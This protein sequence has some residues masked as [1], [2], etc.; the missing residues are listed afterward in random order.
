MTD[1]PRKG[2]KMRIVKVETLEDLLIV[3][4]QREPGETM[5]LE[6][7]GE[8]LA[9]AGQPVADPSLPEEEKPIEYLEAFGGEI[10][11]YADLVS[12]DIS[13]ILRPQFDGTYVLDLRDIHDERIITGRKKNGALAQIK[14][15]RCLSKHGWPD[16]RYYMLKRDDEENIVPERGDNSRDIYISTDPE[17]WTSARIG[18]AQKPAISAAAV[19]GAWLLA[20]PQYGSTPDMKV[21]IEVAN[22]IKAE[23]GKLTQPF[24][25][26]G[27]SD[28]YYLEAGKA[29]YDGLTFYVTGDNPLHPIV[30]TRFG[31]GHNPSG[32]QFGGNGA[33]LPGNI[34]FIGVDVGMR[35]ARGMENVLVSDCN[36][37]PY[38]GSDV[39]SMGAGFTMYRMTGLD[40]QREFP[41]KIGGDAVDT[42][43]DENANR[44]SGAYW[45]KVLGSLVEAC[46]YDHN[47]WG[48]GYSPLRLWNNGKHPQPPSVFS[49]NIY[50]QKFNAD[51]T[52]KDIL[53]MRSASVAGQ[54]RIGGWQM[55]CTSLDN[56]IAFQNAGVH[57][58][59][60]EPDKKTENG[61]FPFNLR[62]AAHIGN[63]RPYGHQQGGKITGFDWQGARS[64]D[65]DCVVLHAA[66]PDDPADIASKPKHGKAATWGRG[67]KYS[68]LVVI[69]WDGD[70]NLDGLN[71]AVAMQITV[72]RWIGKELGKDRGSIQE[73]ATYMRGLTPRRRQLKMREFNLYLVSARGENLD[74]PLKA[75]TKAQKVIFK[76]SWKAEGRRLDNPIN[77]SVKTNLIDGDDLDL[78]G[79][80]ADWVLETRNLKS[81]STGKDGLLNVSSGAV[82]FQEA[83]D[84]ANLRVWNAGELHVNSAQ[85]SR[86]TVRG[87]RFSVTEPS[88]GNLE[89]SGW[90]QVCLGQ[91]WTVGEGEVFCIANDLGKVG[92]DS[93]S[94]SGRLTI[95]A[96]GTLKFI[97]TPVIEYGPWD[98]TAWEYWLNGFK[99]QTSGAE[100]NFDG[101]RRVGDRA[102]ARVRNMV[103]TPVLGELT[104][105]GEYLRPAMGKIAAIHPA[106]V[107]RFEAGWAGRAGTVN[108]EAT[109]QVILE[110][111]AKVVLEGREYMAAK[112]YDLGGGTGTRVTFVDQGATKDTGFSVNDGKL[113]LAIS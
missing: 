68:N 109:F 90:G 60:M 11:E 25:K 83:D 32:C 45:A 62:S 106:T 2:N 13:G 31:D 8:I 46:F 79:N 100:G 37:E 98:F 74:L 99:G 53:S 96:G 16:A 111:D 85:K 38:F 64:V 76:P 104:T 30:V 14:V 26:T 73:F 72:Q 10:N 55:G 24:T 17:A 1:N 6:A 107:G 21:S 54:M 47:G 23:R 34:V 75:R 113:T 5:I 95:K 4:A 40:A 66:D 65:V 89:A 91:N 101:L 81:L 103:G 43:F 51:M 44:M 87:G 41:I 92:W 7:N 27:P 71:K 18:A 3:T 12:V 9:I 20:R 59:D 69:G 49:H 52:F 78:F 28:W 70:L 33:G 19:T 58:S 36:G 94:P 48:E 77:L 97:A 56:P 86:V 39:T 61:F 22:K 15:N 112:T 67:A 88:S 84:G 108:S 29:S 63:N 57:P 93:I 82:S 102:Y 42:W 110:G 80:P 105:K 35:R 50:S